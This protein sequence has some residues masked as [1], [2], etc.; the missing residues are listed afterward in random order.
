MR[1]SHLLYA[2]WIAVGFAVSVPAPARAAPETEEAVSPLDV[3]PIRLGDT[4]ERVHATYGADFEE[5]AGGDNY[6]KLGLRFEYDDEARV[7]SVTVG[8][9]GEGTYHGTVYGVKAASMLSAWREAFGPEIA[10]TNWRSLG[11]QQY[12]FVHDGLRFRVEAWEDDGRTPETGL[13]VRTG[14][15][16]IEVDGRYQDAAAPTTLWGALDRG[17]SV[18]RVKALVPGAVAPAKPEAEGKLK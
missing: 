16:S 11:T 9:F 15:R 6:K 8:W 10:R 17:M 3:M 4:R 1:H 5:R 13:H 14:V 18:K 7:R 12:T 2:W